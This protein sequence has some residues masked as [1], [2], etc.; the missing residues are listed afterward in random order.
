M[1]ES[2][3]VEGLSTAIA[4]TCRLLWLL[5]IDLLFV[6]REQRAIPDVAV[7]N[8]LLSVLVVVLPNTVVKV[9]DRQITGKE[10]VSVTTIDTEQPYG[11]PLGSV[12]VLR[13]TAQDLR[14]PG[15]AVS[16]TALGMMNLLI[17]ALGICQNLIHDTVHQI[18]VNFR[19]HVISSRVGLMYAR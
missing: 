3:R 11:I 2:L 19:R 7:L 18:N 1:V 14:P 4:A 10:Q 15:K 16:R 12:V 6:N 13:L 17:P 8:T 5:R 9:A